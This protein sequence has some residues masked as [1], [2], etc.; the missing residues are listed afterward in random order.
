M[1][2]KLVEAY[3]N[4]Q[5]M[6]SHSPSGRELATSPIFTTTHQIVS[7]APE[8]EGFG[9]FIGM[10][11]S[12]Y[13][14]ADLREVIQE[15]LMH[16]VLSESGDYR[17]MLY[18]I[19]S[20]NGHTAEA[21]INRM[22][23]VHNVDFSCMVPQCDPE[24]AEMAALHKLPLRFYAKPT[25]EMIEQLAVSAKFPGIVDFWMKALS[26]PEVETMGDWA[27]KVDSYAIAKLSTELGFQPSAIRVMDFSRI[28]EQLPLLST[29]QL[30][31]TVSELSDKGDNQIFMRFSHPQRGRLAITC[32]LTL[33]DPQNNFVQVEKDEFSNQLL[34]S[35]GSLNLSEVLASF[36]VQLSGIG[37]YMCLDL[38]AS[39]IKGTEDKSAFILQDDYPLPEGPMIAALKMQSLQ[40]T[41]MPRVNI[42]RENGNGFSYDT[43]GEFGQYAFLG[44]QD[45][46]KL[47]D[48][49]EILVRQLNAGDPTG[50]A[51]I[52]FN[53]QEMSFSEPFYFPARRTTL[54]LYEASREIDATQ[55]FL[56]N[57][58]EVQSMPIWSKILYALRPEVI[59]P[60]LAK[61]RGEISKAEKTRDMLGQIAN[62]YSALNQ[63]MP[64]GLLQLAHAYK[65]VCDLLQQS[66]ALDNEYKNLFSED[67]K[68]RYLLNHFVSII[69]ASV[70]LG[71]PV[72]AMDKGTTSVEELSDA[73]SKARNHL[74]TYMFQKVAQDL[75]TQRD[76]SIEDWIRHQ[77]SLI[78][79][80]REEMRLYE[81]L[82]LV[83]KQTTDEINL[84]GIVNVSFANAIS[85]LFQKWT[86][87]KDATIAVMGKLD[88]DEI[89]LNP[90]TLHYFLEGTKQ[91]VELLLESLLPGF[92]PEVFSSRGI[93]KEVKIAIDQH[94]RLVNQINFLSVCHPHL[95]SEELKDSASST[96]YEHT[97]SDWSSKIKSEVDKKMQELEEEAKQTWQNLNNA[98]GLEEKVSLRQNLSDRLH[99]QINTPLEELIRLID[100]ILANRDEIL[101]QY[102]V[103]WKQATD[104]YLNIGTEN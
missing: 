19:D 33:V 103:L 93:A 104:L 72:P 102:A 84:S 80:L 26:D 35:M 17:S 90:N 81:D 96:E 48:L 7:K 78:D 40:A 9:E 18:F 98:T 44:E 74:H 2:I 13:L 89:T 76:S 100:A 4:Q 31:K 27:L 60:H 5:E 36:P 92:E 87:A 14:G 43:P 55:G 91:Q 22:Q 24:L 86:A 12:S 99:F 82:V 83:R 3:R 30:I 88:K 45:Y 59:A 21:F 63:T 94:E 41:V 53:Q 62:L 46:K 57:S 11:G 77:R 101:A 47:R 97:K 85:R 66:E 64:D 54:A 61:F 52:N 95:S 29:Q 58:S 8:L 75:E 42:G 20:N 73:I 49:V 1:S 15:L 79:S 50:L 71:L 34:E 39:S 70:K 32:S 6:L 67:E 10:Y 25:V 28:S 38:F 56:T 65:K 37:Y 68:K 23:K 69:Q 16:K 51:G